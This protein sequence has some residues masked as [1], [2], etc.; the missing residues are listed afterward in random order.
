MLSKIKILKKNGFQV[1][2]YQSMKDSDLQKKTGKKLCDT[3]L[4][5]DFLVVTLKTGFI[6]ETI[7]WAL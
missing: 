3:G 5:K 4:G 1:I 7:N 6:K 2:L